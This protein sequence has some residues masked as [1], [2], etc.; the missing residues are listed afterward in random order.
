MGMALHTLGDYFAHNSYGLK[1]T[2]TY[3]CLGNEYQHAVN[4]DNKFV[5]ITHGIN[6]AA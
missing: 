4:V 6:V 2:A 3:Y 1:E 5:R